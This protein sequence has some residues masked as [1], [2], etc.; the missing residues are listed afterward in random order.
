MALD[1]AGQL[2]AREPDIGSLITKIQEAC[3]SESNASFARENAGGL[4]SRL[5]P[6]VARPIVVHDLAFPASSLQ[7]RRLQ[8][9]TFQDCYFQPTSIHST[10]LRN[11]RF[12]RC[13]F[14]RIELFADG[15]VEETELVECTVRSV[16]SHNSEEEV[17]DPLRVSR[18]L[19]SS[20][21]H[22]P[23]P[24]VAVP[25]LQL[26]EIEPDLS[27][28]LRVFRVFA[29]TTEVNESVFRARAGKLA[30][31]FQNHLLPELVRVGIVVPVE[32]RGAGIQRRF[33]LAARLTQLQQA[34][35]NAGG[36]YTEFLR[37]VQKQDDREGL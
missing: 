20:G 16:I 5:L 35:E 36:S 10:R 17:F 26:A 9:V 22:F 37:L 1:A 27:L 29:R 28:L 12:V 25:D 18:I 6:S 34:E 23:T 21:F 24:I 32:Y 15:L 33:R 13:E 19:A 31:R 30:S 11:C 3:H 4:I 14:E 8:H 7:D 2:L